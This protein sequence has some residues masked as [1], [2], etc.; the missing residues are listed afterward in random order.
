MVAILMLLWYTL[1]LQEY[2]RK[3]NSS[4][5]NRQKT[6]FVVNL[7]MNDYMEKAIS[8]LPCNYV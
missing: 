8:K 4:M 1:T 2:P 3:I 7:Y 6:I 5:V